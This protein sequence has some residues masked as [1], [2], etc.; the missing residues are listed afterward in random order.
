MKWAIVFAF[1]IVLALMFLYEWPK[2]KSKEKKRKL[3]LY[4]CWQWGGFLV[5]FFSFTRIRPDLPIW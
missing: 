2:I 5:S 3:F 4:A 1:T